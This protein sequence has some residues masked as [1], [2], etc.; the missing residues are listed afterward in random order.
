M[1]IIKCTNEYACEVSATK[2]NDKDVVKIDFNIQ[3]YQILLK[4]RGWTEIPYP[5][6]YLPSIKDKLY[7]SGDNLYNVII[8]LD[9][10]IETG[11]IV[12]TE[13]QYTNRGFSFLNLKDD[14]GNVVSIQKS[15]TMGEDL[16]WFGTKVNESDIGEKKDGKF[17]R[18]KYDDNSGISI[19]D[20]LHI[21]QEQA[22]KL[23]LSIITEI[24]NTWNSHKVADL[25]DKK[26]VN[27]NNIIIDSW[28]NLKPEVQRINF[29]YAC[30]K[31][32]LDLVKKIYK[33]PEN[34]F[35]NEL[36]CTFEEFGIQMS[37]Q[38]E[39]KKVLKFFKE[40]MK[41]KAMELSYTMEKWVRDNRLGR[42]IKLK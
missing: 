17:I 28:G 18:Y 34:K 21:N 36:F 31:G 2:L 30:G 14:L 33:N 11:D 22:Q 19:Q 32:N 5:K 39:S 41:E 27:A 12:T 1:S 20:R 25:V 9:T 3:S 15:S 40:C 4:F 24:S 8:A 37:M 29:M 26:T 23:R 42:K 35:L 6:E 7:L 10:F 16:L 38:P 13:T